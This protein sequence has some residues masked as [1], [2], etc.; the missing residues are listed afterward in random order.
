MNKKLSLQLYIKFD[1]HIEVKPG[2]IFLLD[3]K[4]F[5]IIQWQTKCAI[6]VS[7]DKYSRGR[8]QS[9]KGH[10]NNKIT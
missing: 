5:P 1:A 4:Q 9:Q 8:K 3:F 7:I 2:L 6:P 10:T